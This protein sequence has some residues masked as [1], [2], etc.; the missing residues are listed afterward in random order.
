MRKAATYAINFVFAGA[1]VIALAQTP[2]QQTA[3]G[4]PGQGRQGAS[5]GGQQPPSG[6][7]PNSQYRLGPDSLP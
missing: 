6:P 3:P 5:L 1:S 4:Q 2:A 7:N